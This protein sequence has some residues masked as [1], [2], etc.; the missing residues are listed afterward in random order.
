MVIGISTSE[1]EFGNLPLSSLSKF[2]T[3]S[4]LVILT[5]R[6]WAIW[7]RGKWIGF[8][9]LVVAIMALT[10]VI[11]IEDIY[12]K[13]V[14]CELSFGLWTSV[15]HLTFSRLIASNA[16]TS[17][18]S[19][20]TFVSLLVRG[21]DQRV[22]VVCPHLQAPSLQA[23]SLLWLLSKHVNFSL[24]PYPT[25]IDLPSTT[26]CTGVNSDENFPSTY[27]HAFFFPH[28]RW[29]SWLVRRSG[30][31]SLL[32]K[33]LRDGILFCDSFMTDHAHQLSRNNV[34]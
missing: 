13:S 24:I 6:T 23:A 8:I 32:T 1:S 10:P 15:N 20:R 25:Y 34:L 28:P 14:I 33:V 30:R 12:L 29:N 11:V 4:S 2:G 27:V 21:N 3:W 19:N 16:T 18:V 26:S 9:L 22:S 17:R 5:V 7:G 31:S